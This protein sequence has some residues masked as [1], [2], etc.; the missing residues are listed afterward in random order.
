[1]TDTILSTVTFTDKL[2]VSLVQGN[3]SDEMVLHAARVSTTGLMGDGIEWNDR[4]NGLI[5]YLMNNQH[6]SPFEHGSVTFFVHAPIFVAREFMRHRS[7]SYNEESG[8]Y[9]QLEPVFYVPNAA[10][11]LTQKGKPG[12]YTFLPGSEDQY[13]STEYNLQ[14]VYRTAY[15]AYERLLQEGI[16]REVARMVLPVGIMTSFYATANM[17]NVL[18][19]L[20]LRLDESAQQEI[21]EVASQ[22]YTI[23]GMLAPRTVLAWT[24]SK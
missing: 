24:D 4:D 5:K 22:M 9:K 23:M 20:A 18:N 16:A 11:P 1:M 3:V 17:R 12:A 19:F 8:R 21:R 13:L 6:M 14:H 10:R 2:T 15:A 7:F